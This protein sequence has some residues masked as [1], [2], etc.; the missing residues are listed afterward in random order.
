MAEPIDSMKQ[1]ILSAVKER[2]S[3]DGFARLSVD[4]LT[5]GMGMSKKTF[6]KAFKSKEQMIGEFVD[7][8]MG[9]IGGGLDRI[10][11]NDVGFVEKLNAL[12]AHLGTLSQRIDS[13]LASDIHRTMPHLW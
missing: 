2:L 6:Y 1:R 3:R 4:E 12:M 5:A 11:A 13:L 8:T 7:R 10:I 9:E